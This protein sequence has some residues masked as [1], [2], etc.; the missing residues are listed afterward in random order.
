[1]LLGLNLNKSADNDFE[2]DSKKE[3]KSFLNSLKE[4]LQN[5]LIAI[6]MPEIYMT[7]LFYLCVGMTE[8]SFGEFSYYFQMNVVKFTKFEYAMF[9]VLG[10]TSLS[11][12]TVYYNMYLK[13][14]EVRTL[15]RY[16]CLISCFGAL[17]NLT[18]AYRLNLQIG[19]K[20]IS[21]ILFTDVVLG[22]LGLAYS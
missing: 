15:L 17:L 1:M 19:I 4:S 8:P 12:G 10:Y 3:K 2:E 6:K 14:K 5:I 9:G 16:A 11:L 7:L 13:E 21:Y 20:D 18:F 22:T